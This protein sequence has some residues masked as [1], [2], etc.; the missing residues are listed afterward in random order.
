MVTEREPTLPYT[1][2]FI[3]FK[4]D[5]LHLLR[6]ASVDIEPGDLDLGRHWDNIR[7][8]QRAIRSHPTVTAA[9][10]CAQFIAIPVTTILRCSAPLERIRD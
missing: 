5:Q 6:F 8:A 2:E 3:D 4:S 9:T 7:D 1:S 10:T